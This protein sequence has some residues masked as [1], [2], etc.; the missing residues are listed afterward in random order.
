[1]ALEWV[2]SMLAQC[3]QPGIRMVPFIK[4]L[5]SVAGR[6]LGTGSKGGD[7]DRWPEDLKFRGFP[8]AAAAVAA[9]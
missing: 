9:S 7:W 6:E 1:M 5:G 2:R 4:Q 3:Q 8:A